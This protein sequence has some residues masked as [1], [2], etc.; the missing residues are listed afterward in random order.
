MLAME[1]TKKIE[2]G[3]NAAT[4]KSLKNTTNNVIKSYKCNKCGYTSLR[5]GDLRRHLTTHSEEKPNKCNQ[6][7]YASSRADGLRGH[8]KTHGGEKPN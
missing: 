6:C 8:L 4:E 1:Q 2:F 5:L 7:D 3:L